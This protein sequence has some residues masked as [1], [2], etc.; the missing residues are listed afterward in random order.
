MQGIFA[1]SVSLDAE[2]GIQKTTK[3]P[4]LLDFSLYQLDC[5]GVVEMSL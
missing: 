1:F 4:A 3:S 2:R 5:F